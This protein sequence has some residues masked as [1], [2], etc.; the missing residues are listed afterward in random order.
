MVFGIWALVLLF[1][2]RSRL[3]KAAEQARLSWA[4]TA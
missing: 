1:M 2:F 3:R 4:R